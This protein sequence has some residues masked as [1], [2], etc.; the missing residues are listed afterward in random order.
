MYISFDEVVTFDHL[1]KSYFHCR[2]GKAFRENTIDYHRNYM[3]NLL[4]LMRRLQDGTYKIR[5]LYSFIIYEPKKRSITANQFED[6]IVQRLICKYALEPTIS[7]KLIYD[8]YASQN[9]KGPHL[10][11][12][13]LQ[14]F[15]LDFAKSVNWTDE[16]WVLVCD[17]HKF[18]YTIDRTI[19]CEQVDNLEIDSRLK[20]LVYDQIYAYDSRY[21]EYTDDPNKGIC[22]GFQ[23]S[24]WLAVYYLNGLDHLIK[25]KLHIKYYG[26][27]MDDLYIIHKDREY[28]EHCFDVIKEYIEDEL[29]MKLNPKS[30]IHPFSQGVCFL[31]YHCTYNVSTHQIDTIIRNKSVRRMKRRANRQ[32]NLIKLGK[33]TKENANNSLESWYA[34]AKYGLSTQADNTYRHIK[35]M[36]YPYAYELELYQEELK[37]P[38]KIDKDGFYI[39]RPKLP[40]L[41]K[42]VETKREYDSRI[43]KERVLNDI[44]FYSNANADALL[45][46]TYKNGK[47]NKKSSVLTTKR[48]LD[49]SMDLLFIDPPSVK[50]KKKQKLK[51]SW[52]F[53]DQYRDDSGFVVLKHK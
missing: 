53:Q 4:K 34:Y 5:D 36:I 2:K 24:Q 10:G 22:I 38:D 47:K 48:S 49:E 23:T 17:I 35:D 52:K 32:Q 50:K 39:L 37:D 12:H 31:G 3:S 6:K 44:F 18:F 43:M 30:H 9:N 14:K 1:L 46:H 51:D 45:N 29:N 20:S 21:N 7:P 28:L 42:P 40:E 19:C 8:N 25:E 26:R 41:I 27:Y 15:M 33:I 13:R 16:G 11:I